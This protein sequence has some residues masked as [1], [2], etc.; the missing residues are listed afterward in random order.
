M[1]LLGLEELYAGHRV[2][3]ILMAVDESRRVSRSLNKSSRKKLLDLL[4]A[5]HVAIRSV[6][7]AEPQR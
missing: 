1:L 5:H 6:A 2:R 4:G 3:G 7:T